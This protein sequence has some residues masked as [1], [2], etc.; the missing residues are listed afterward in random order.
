VVLTVYL[1][2]LGVAGVLGALIGIVKPVELDPRLFF[3][4]ELPPTPLGMATFGVVTVGVGLGVLL[5]LVQYVSR[6]DEDR[7]E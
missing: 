6:F 5:L 2:V 1:A 7:I 4:V 3:L